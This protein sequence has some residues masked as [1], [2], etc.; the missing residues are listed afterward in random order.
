MN[1]TGGFE[2]T[3]RAIIKGAWE[4]K[5]RRWATGNR[6]LTQNLEQ[7]RPFGIEPA[8]GLP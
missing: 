1:K 6:V 7:F 5:C 2:K 4:E 8:R 3:S